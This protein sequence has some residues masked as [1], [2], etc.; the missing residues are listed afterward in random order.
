MPNETER[1][2]GKL[3]SRPA[4]V[5]TAGSVG[6]CTQARAQKARHQAAAALA[7]AAGVV[8]RTA[9]VAQGDTV[10]LHWHWLSLTVI[11]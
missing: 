8:L 2:A 4:G 3:A 11:A 1:G 5:P 6:S 7:T 10:I 9:L